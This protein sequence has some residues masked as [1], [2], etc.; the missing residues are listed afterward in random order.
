MS[1]N[2][3]THDVDSKN[4]FCRHSGK[5]ASPHSAKSSTSTTSPAGL[6][7][8]LRQN[9][10]SAERRRQS[11]LPAQ[12]SPFA[13]ASG[14]ADSAHSTSNGGLVRRALR[15]DSGHS[16]SSTKAVVRAFRADEDE[17]NLEGFEDISAELDAIPALPEPLTAPAYPQVLWACNDGTDGHVCPA[18]INASKMVCEALY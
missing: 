8:R 17:L 12:A 7:A 11:P 9:Q 10:P 5:A 16:T 14:R 1:A 6:S 3:S 2:S 13:A 18:V 15:A 4:V